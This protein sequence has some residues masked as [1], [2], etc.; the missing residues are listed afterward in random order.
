MAFVIVVV[1]LA[2]PPPSLDRSRRASAL[3]LATD[4]SILRGFLTPDSKWRLPVA[5]EAVDPLYRQI[6]VAAEDRHFDRHP[7]VDPIAATRALFQLGS[8]GHIVSGA[9]TLTMQAARLLEPHPRSFIGKLR[10]AAQALALERQMSK[11]KIEGLYLTLAPFGGNL[12]GVRAASLAYFGKEPTRLSA[13]EAALLVAIPRSPERLR[14]DRHPDAARAAR[15]RVLLRMADTGVIS[16]AKL[17]EARAEPVPRARL[18]MPFHAPH[19]ARE[20]RDQQ[21]TALVHH[22]TIDL[23][24]QRR[25]EALLKREV[26]GLESEASLAAIVVDNRDRG[27]RAYVGNADFA[28]AARRGTVDMARVVRSPGSA[29]KSFIYAMGF[30]RL[31]IHPETTLEDRTRHFGD[32]TPNDFDGRFEGE[33]TARQALQYSLNLPAVAV[34]DRLGPDRFIAALGAAGIR[35]RL[36]QPTAKPG[37]A[38]ALGGAGVT[39]VDLLQ[40]YASLSNGGKVTPLRYRE[41]DPV[42]SGTA[43][44]GPLAAWYVNDILA[45]A[46]P[47]ATVLPAEVRNGRRLAFKT[48]TSYGFRDFWAIGYDPK[49][50]IGVWAGRPDGTPM[51]GRSGRLTAAPVLFKIADLL[52]AVR[53]RHP[54][55]PPPGVLLVGR[56]DLP[57]RLSRLDPGAQATSQTSGPRIIF[58]PDGAIIEWRGEDVPLEAIGGKQ[59]LH[60]LVDG[61][62][63]SP[64]PPRRGIH[65][66][67]EGIGF[68]RL[69][70]IDAAG[71]SAH[72]TVQ[73]S[74]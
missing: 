25:V 13:A 28:S 65:W 21:P 35:L 59:P 43:I 50:T 1:Y 6:L 49:V 8:S 34:L 66:E 16:P 39:L 57:P 5:P 17:A 71:R 9:S 61:R 23:F 52:D 38:V 51:P 32:Y 69:S 48:G 19:L 60:W 46:P 42:T 55:R 31:I 40:L 11:D 26:S 10:E 14:P 44:F 63:L 45:E 47:P 74:P 72:S 54:A 68:A 53:L 4:G 56:N 67:P 27:V 18:A 20:L 22:S 41:D 2:L 70:V 12:E 37:L 30:D 29:L 24:L 58:P 33:V 73:L 15:D 7:G 36:P 3:V 62:P 64:G